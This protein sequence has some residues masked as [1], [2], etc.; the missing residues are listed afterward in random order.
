M[1]GQ[2]DDWMTGH[3]TL[4]FGIHFVIQGSINWDAYRCLYIQ[5]SDSHFFISALA[6]SP[7]LGANLCHILDLYM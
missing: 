6:L 7:S 1:T 3:V 4:F 5:C 2:L